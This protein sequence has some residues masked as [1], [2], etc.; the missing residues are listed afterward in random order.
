M[1]KVIL[2]KRKIGRF[3]FII[4][5]FVYSLTCFAQINDASLSTQQPVAKESFFLEVKLEISGDSDPYISFDASGCEVLGRENVGEQISTV[6]INGRISTS[7]NKITRFEIICDKPGLFR[8]SDIAAEINGKKYV[9][10]TISFRVVSKAATPDDVFVEAV[11]DK[12]DVFIGE[13]IQLNYYLYRRVSVHAH[14]IKQFPKLNGFIKRFHMPNSNPE[15]VQSGSEIYVRLL[16]YSAKI[17]P[18]ISGD[19][20]IDPIKLMVQYSSESFG[21][22][23]G[24]FGMGRLKTKTLTSQ[25]IVIK[26]N[27]LPVFNLDGIFSGLVG[28]NQFELLVTRSRFI[29]NET[30]EAKLIAKGE[31]ALENMEGPVLYTHNNIESF[32]VKSTFEEL[33]LKLARKVFDYTYIGRNKIDIPARKLNIYTFNSSKKIFELHALQLPNLSVAASSEQTSVSGASSDNSMSEDIKKIEVKD[34]IKLAPVKYKI[35]SPDFASNFTAKLSWN[36]FKY[37]TWLVFIFPLFYTIIILVKNLKSRPTKELRRVLKS[38][39]FKYKDVF[40][41]VDRISGM[42]YKDSQMAP[43]DFFNSLTISQKS[44][45]YFM[46]LMIN[47][48][49]SDFNLGQQYTADIDS[50]AIQELDEFV[51]ARATEKELNE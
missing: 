32:D 25:N 45:D 9:Y 6:I 46:S 29:A 33:D 22:P 2:M 5:T 47:A 12:T 40:A 13:G 26:S 3:I 16:L 4:I 34:L 42:I 23:F 49:H 50:R 48:E 39:N 17:F 15:R 35:V 27:Q 43:R 19:L 1:K 41:A 21:S 44:K 24:A 18:E 14:E 30:I 8:I 11:V 7:R 51:R 28:E 20:N 37:I 38:K 31:G 10:Q 36:L